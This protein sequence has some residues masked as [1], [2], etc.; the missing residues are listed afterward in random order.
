MGEM[1]FEGYD[2]AE[3]APVEKVS[4]DRRRTLRQAAYVA[5]GIHP[6]TK[7]RLHPLASRNRDA[8]SPKSDPYT[9]GSCYFRIV[10]KYHDR[11]YPKCWLPGPVRAYR[12]GRDGE[13]RWETIEGAP[14]ATHSAASDVRAWWPACEQYVPGDS[15]LSPDAARSI[16]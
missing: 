8:D 3:P 15:S 9:C 1:L 10:D 14:R 2:P 4:A 12:K 11:S 13:W 5:A 7:G 16:P 6:L